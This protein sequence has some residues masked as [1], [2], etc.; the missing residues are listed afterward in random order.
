MEFIEHILAVG[1]IEG[2]REDG[3]KGPAEEGK[4]CV[5]TVVA[6]SAWP[7]SG[8]HL[9]HKTCPNLKLDYR[10]QWKCTGAQD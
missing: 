6:G 3:R 9:S 1:W 10:G 5:L 7:C 4:A 2:R 8:V